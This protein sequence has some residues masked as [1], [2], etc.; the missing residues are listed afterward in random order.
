M[1]A[2][3]KYLA[4]C[5]DPNHVISGRYTFPLDLS[6]TG[7]KAKYLM[8]QT[9]AAAKQETS[10]ACPDGVIVGAGP[11]G[12][13]AAITL[14]RAGYTVQVYEAK[15]TIGGGARTAELTLPGFKHDICSAI[16]P[17]GVGSPF[18][19]DL[20]LDRYGLEWIFPHYAAAHPLDDGTAV[21]IQNSI[22][23][24]AATMGRDAEAYQRLMI[25]LVGNW[26]K[27][28]LDVLGSKPIPPRYPIA[29]AQFGML[30]LLP[31]SALIKL[32][33][34]GPRARAVFAGMAAHSMIPLDYAAT[35]SFGLMLLLLA[36]AIG[37][38]MARGGS[39]AIV[40]AMAKYLESLGGKI[41]TGMPVTSM[42]QLPH[43]QSVLFDVTPRQLLAIAGERLPENY[44]KG[45]KRFHYGPGVFK[46]DYAL[47]GP[48]PWKASA[49][50]QAG[51]V[52]V[53]GTFEEIQTAEQAVWRGEHPER[54]F[55][56][57]AQQSLFDATRAPGG[58]HTLW[59]Y[60]H[61]PNGSTQD[62]TGAIEEQIERFAPGFRSRILFRRSANAQQMEQYNPNYVGG[63]INGGA[64]TIDQFFTRPVPSWVP[65]A[66]P[67][68][69]IYICSSSTPPGGGVHGMCGYQAAKAVLR[70]SSKS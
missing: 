9:H 16:H 30:A 37:W 63:D 60:C 26:K 22:E 28:L 34:R 38:P 18:F 7:R 12:L 62:M 52:H 31:A 66:T 24:S 8:S 53:G 33:F 11:N 50:R 15:D 20:P 6:Q 35:A 29:T 19:Q 69:G 4:Q 45:M 64:Q 13:A 3:E 10:P 42:N 68:K 5:C 25:P 41:T 2:S 1:V 56:L 46:V 32:F 70:D 39:Q 47:D 59:A 36:H 61:V 55:V 49:C 14:A 43:S 27:I 57:L 54:P 65:Y 23:A 48:I 44:Q 21:V 67:A 58:M 51:T 40:N 17:L